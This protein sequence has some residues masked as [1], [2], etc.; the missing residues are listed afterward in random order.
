MRLLAQRLENQLL[1]RPSLN[2]P[3]E[4]VSWFGAIQAQDYL[5][6]LWA[7]GL[8]TR[9]STEKTIETALAQGSLIR[10]HVFRG[11]WQFVTPADARWMLALVGKRAIAAAASR[12]RSFGL[13]TKTLGR[14]AELFA[15]AL[16]GGRQ[17]TRSEMGAALARRGIE[18]AESRLMHILW[19]AE[20]SGLITSGARRGKQQTFALFDERVPKGSALSREQALAELARRY[21][22]SRGPATER[23]FAWWTGLTLGDARKAIEL[24]SRGL[25][26]L[27]LGGKRYWLGQRA[28]SARRSSNVQLLPAFDE[29]LVAY[30]DRSACIDAAQARKVNAGGGLLKPALVSEGQVIGTWRRTLDGRAVSVTVQPFTKLSAAQRHDVAAACARYAAFLGLPLRWST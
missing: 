22:E 28:R 15:R 25:Q 24:A 19:H 18:L 5:A 6:A 4:A 1:T 16:E 14:C 3:A 27:E 17:L 26:S 10:T 9:G 11:T 29:Y 21:F 8:R 2:S 7:L 20:L 13:D 23:D 12:L 30:Q